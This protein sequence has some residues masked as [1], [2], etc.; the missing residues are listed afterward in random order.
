MITNNCPFCHI[1]ANEIV[2]SN[3]F[4][5]IIL[6]RYPI[7]PG[8]MLVIPKRHV[9]SV[10]EITKREQ[11]ALLDAI[12]LAK[13]W[14][15]RKHKPDG[16]NVGINDGIVAGQTVMHLHVH[17]IPRYKGDL[18]DPRGGIRWILPEK[19]DYWSI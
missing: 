9:A 4:A 14:L 11:R 15:E 12:G 6:D 10:S 1:K 16:Y 3:R 18:S 5:I 17:V 2:S 13:T 8:H 7:S 19:A